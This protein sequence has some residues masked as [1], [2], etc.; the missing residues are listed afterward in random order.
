LQK[1]GDIGPGFLS[2][3]DVDELRMNFIHGDLVKN[4]LNNNVS[5]AK[6]IG[7]KVG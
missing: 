2:G 5:L 3:D 6:E 7:L 1:V 4:V